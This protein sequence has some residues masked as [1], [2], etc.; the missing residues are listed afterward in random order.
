MLIGALVVLT[1]A[2]VMLPLP[3]LPLLPLHVNV[4][5]PELN[6]GIIFKLVPEQNTFGPA[7]TLFPTG[8]GFTVTTIGANGVP[9]QPF[10]LGVIIYCT[11]PPA[12]L[13]NV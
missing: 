7:A 9:G 1:G 10:A 2:S 12:A 13:V 4:P 3:P 11:V 5:D 6:V 8:I